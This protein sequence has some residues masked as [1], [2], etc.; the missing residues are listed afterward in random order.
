MYGAFRPADAFALDAADYAAGI[1]CAGP[2]GLEHTA[3]CVRSWV[4]GR[5][6]RAPTHVDN[7]RAILNGLVGRFQAN[8]DTVTGTKNAVGRSFAEIAAHVEVFLI[9]LVTKV[10]HAGQ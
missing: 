10:L 6:C 3:P 8:V 2:A 1:G 5:C 4:G 7:V 9:V